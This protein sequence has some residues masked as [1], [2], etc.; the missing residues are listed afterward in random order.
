MPVAKNVV[1]HI[2]E[3]TKMRVMIMAKILSRYLKKYSVQD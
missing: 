1:S 2:L 3:K